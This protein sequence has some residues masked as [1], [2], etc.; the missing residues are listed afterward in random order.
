MNPYDNGRPTGR[1]SFNLRV[2]RRQPRNSVSPP[3]HSTIR[4]PIA[5]ITPRNGSPPTNDGDADDRE[6]RG[7]AERDDGQPE[8]LDERARGRG[9]RRG[10]GRPRAASL[11]VGS[12]GSG[13]GHAGS[14]PPSASRYGVPYSSK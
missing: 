11:G 7:E 3:T 9:V 4:Q 14:L 6:Q 12:S 2:T 8:P 10:A 1:D 5:P 13:V